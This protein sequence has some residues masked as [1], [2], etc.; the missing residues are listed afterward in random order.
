MSCSMK[1]RVYLATV[2]SDSTSDNG[3]KD[4]LFQPITGLIPT[5]GFSAIRFSVEVLAI[6][7]AMRLEVGGRNTNDGK[8]FGSQYFGLSE[9][10]LPEIETVGWHYY[11]FTNT[12]GAERYLQFGMWGRRTSSGSVRQA[13]TVRF[14]LE[15]KSSLA[16][17]VS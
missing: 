5:L 8:N 17:V 12:P 1:P 15:F 16:G 9:A 2:S 7:P 3:S 6:S 10:S 4:G 13:A 14:L 11:V